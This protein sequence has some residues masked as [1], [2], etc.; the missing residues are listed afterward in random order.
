[1]AGGDEYL[2]RLTRYIHLN[3]V[4]TEA[5]GRMS[6]EERVGILRKY[7]WSS[8]SGYVD[9]KKAQNWVDYRWLKLMGCRT[10]GANRRAYQRYVETMAAGEDDKLK[11]AQNASRYAIGDKEFCGEV[12]EELRQAEMRATLKDDVSWPEK[13][14]VEITS[15]A[16]AVSDEYGLKEGD[17]KG[18]SRRASVAKKVAVELACRYTEKSQREI[19]LHFGYCSGSAVGKQRQSLRRLL[20]VPALVRRMSKLEKA[21][22]NG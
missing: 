13:K 6:A 4:K 11:E 10:M 8:L 2:V 16:S 19:G 21:L 9:G 22:I 5:C 1:V 20:S 12:A 3:P 7:G 14:A 15:V 17:L 18:R